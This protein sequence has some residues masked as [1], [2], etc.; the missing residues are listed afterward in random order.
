MLDK[1]LKSVCQHCAPNEQVL[2]LLEQFR[3][4]LNDCIRIGLETNV[5]SMKSLSLKAY[6]SLAKYDASSRYRLTAISA[7]TGTQTDLSVDNN[8]LICVKQSSGIGS[9]KKFKLIE[10]LI[11]SSGGIRIHVTNA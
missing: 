10:N 8:G 1:A 3:Q 11:A 6:H 4:M 7:A 5:T 2:W 9:V